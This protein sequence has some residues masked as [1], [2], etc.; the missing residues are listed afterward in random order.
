V[1]VRIT[2]LTDPRRGASSH[3][4]AWLA[5]AADGVP[6]GSAFLRLF[7]GAGQDQLAELELHVHPAERR[8]GRGLCCWRRPWPRPATTTGGG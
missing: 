4:L 5:V 8:D 2:P 7:T 1:P 6:V 3:R